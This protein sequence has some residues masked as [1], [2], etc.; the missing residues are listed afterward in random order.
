VLIVVLAV[1]GIEVYGWF[2]F[3]DKEGS[4]SASRLLLHHP[5]FP[6]GGSNRLPRVLSR[7]TRG[8]DS[9]LSHF[10]NA[11]HRVC[12]LAVSHCHRSPPQRRPP[13][14]VVGAATPRRTGARWQVARVCRGQ[15][16]HHPD[17]Q[18]A[19][20]RVSHGGGGAFAA[21]AQGL[22][23]KGRGLGAGGWG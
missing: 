12:G 21:R 1:C 17:S 23:L 10:P 19:G 3:A 15:S 16:V 22:G 18:S 5:S 6:S 7:D 9:A 8:S 20:A 13:D 14:P 4:F 11:S 2:R